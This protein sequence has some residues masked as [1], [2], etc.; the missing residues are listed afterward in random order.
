MRTPKKI[1]S[2]FVRILM[3]SAKKYLQCVVKN[4]A[5]LENPLKYRKIIAN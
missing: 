3:K 2:R 5:M 1:K 4:K